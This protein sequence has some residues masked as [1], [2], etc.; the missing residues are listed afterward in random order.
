MR[1]RETIVLIAVAAFAIAAWPAFIETR[2]A[3]ERAA[4]LATPAPA[5]H[6]YE[7]REALVAFWEGAVR[8]RHHNDMLSPRQLAAQYLQR[9]REKGDIDDVIRARNMAQ[10]SLS[11]MPRNVAALAEMASVMLTLHRFRA[12][13]HFVDECVP[14]DPTGAE[15]LAQQA[16]LEME[17]GEYARA[18]ASL[19]RIASAE[20]SSVPAETIRSRYD[21]LTGN[22]GRA[23]ELL[24]D[25]MMQVDAHIDEPAQARAWYH[26]RAGELAFNAGDTPA[27]VR[28]EQ[29]ALSLFPTDNL[30]LKDLAKFELASHHEQAA[31]AAAIAG[32]RVTPFAETLGYESDAQAALGDRRGAAA[33]RDVIFAIER[34][35]NAYHVNDRLLAVYYAD[36]HLRAAEAFAIARREAAVRGDEIYAQDTLAWASAMDG[37]WAQ[38]RAAAAKATRFDTHDPMVQYHAGIVA[39]HFGDR[40]SATRRLRRALELNAQFH[41][42]FAEDARHKLAAL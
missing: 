23:R 37:R 10:Q 19:R 16:S 9:Y 7:Q 15:F 14:Y 13:L 28:D 30:A 12:A 35:G 17:L 18:D 39:L 25:A 33:T 38:A 1:F 11:I 41:P 32:A 6:D 34:I 2:I 5:P 42:V 27:A 29:A 21:E 26:V 36:H 31:L 3:D 4:S 8:E 40:G 24:D 20:Q 22:L